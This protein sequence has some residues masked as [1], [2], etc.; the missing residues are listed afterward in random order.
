MSAVR[1]RQV[2]DD[3]REAI[4]VGA[5]LMGGDTL[6]AAQKFDCMLGD[7]RLQEQPHKVLVTL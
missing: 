6:A 7:A 5:A 4:L 3:R 2:R 1:R